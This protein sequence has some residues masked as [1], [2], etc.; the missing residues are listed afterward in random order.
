[1]MR[2]GCPQSQDVSVVAGMDRV[3][4]L[5]RCM[6]VFGGMMVFV[7]FGQQSSKFVQLRTAVGTA[8]KV[9]LLALDLRDQHRNTAGP[10]DRPLMENSVL[11]GL[12]VDDCIMDSVDRHRTAESLEE[13][14]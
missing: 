8:G 7:M 1:M 4:D 11:G 6:N 10:A 3:V 2:V 14:P 5:D 9:D 13:Q 12:L